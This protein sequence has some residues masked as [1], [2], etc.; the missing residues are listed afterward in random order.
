MLR[1]NQDVVVALASG[2][3]YI[4]K[5]EIKEPIKVLR[6]LNF[7]VQ[8]KMRQNGFAKL[9]LL[10]I[11][12]HLAINNFSRLDMPISASS[13]Q[14]NLSRLRKLKEFCN[15]SF[16]LPDSAQEKQIVLSVTAKEIAQIAQNK[17]VLLEKSTSSVKLESKESEDKSEPVTTVSP[18]AAYVKPFQT[19]PPSGSS[20][21]IE[22][23]EGKE[24][25]GESREEQDLG[26][27]SS[28]NTGIGLN[29]GGNI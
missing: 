9:L 29:F 7:T 25:K 11:F 18:A 14:L 21:L 1:N 4:S 3:A 22:G 19:T 2:N 5:V 26:E 27:D 8:R 17:D 13:Q 10:N 12:S 6:L 28:T 20:S 23:A 24:S 16:L 15:L